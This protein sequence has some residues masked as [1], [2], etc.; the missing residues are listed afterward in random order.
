MNILEKINFFANSKKDSIAIF[1]GS[2]EDKELTYKE[3]D[4]FSDK[5][6]YYLESLLKSNKNPIVVYGHKN[7]YMIVCFLACV[8]SG[9]AYCPVDILSLIHI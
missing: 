3:L 8:K 9:R 4:D 6:A 5:L 7:P 1:N 2:C